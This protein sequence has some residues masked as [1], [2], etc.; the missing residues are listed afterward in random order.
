MAKKYSIGLDL[1]TS[2]VKAVLFDGEKIIKKASAPFEIKRCALKDGAKYLGFSADGYA[3]TVFGVISELAKE[4]NGNIYGIAM[5]SASDNT[6]VCDKNGKLFAILEAI[7]IILKVAALLLLIILLL[8][9]KS[10][11]K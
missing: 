9:P 6:V 1:G 5:A 8:R 11:S 10:L 3:D 4:V 7:S 2:S